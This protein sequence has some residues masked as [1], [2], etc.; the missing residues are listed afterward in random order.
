LYLVSPSEFLSLLK[1]GVAGRCGVY[2]GL[3]G[4]EKFGPPTPDS[5]GL[6]E[7]LMLVG[8]CL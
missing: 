1:R 7:S 3:L 2:V 6:N 4:G 8:L 5:L